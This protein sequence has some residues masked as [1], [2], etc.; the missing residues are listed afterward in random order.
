[1]KTSVGVIYRFFLVC[2]YFFKSFQK[3]SF[4][5]NFDI[6][7]R[8]FV[9]PASC[10]TVLSVAVGLLSPRNLRVSDEWYTRFR[11]AWDPVA[12][13]VEGYRLTYTPKGEAV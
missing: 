5:T 13:P 10:L 2:R 12:A 4:K 1:M 3:P 7:V 11:V 6:L 9:S 8:L